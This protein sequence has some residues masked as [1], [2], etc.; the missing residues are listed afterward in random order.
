MTMLLEAGAD[1][2]ELEGGE[3][4]DTKESAA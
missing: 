4:H 3:S 1:L 2:H